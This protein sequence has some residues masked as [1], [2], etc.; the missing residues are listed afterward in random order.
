MGVRTLNNH[1]IFPDIKLPI[2]YEWRWSKSGHWDI[3]VKHSDENLL[4]RQIKRIKM[5]HSNQK[6]MARIYYNYQF[7]KC[8]ECGF[9]YSMTY[10]FIPG[11]EQIP[12]NMHFV[13]TFDYDSIVRPRYQKASK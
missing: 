8:E 9:N 3:E 7:G 13:C 1:N 5:F 10:Y 4:E 12:E 2:N 11:E 6:W